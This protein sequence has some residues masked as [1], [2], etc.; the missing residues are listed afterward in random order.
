M[1]F[2]PALSSAEAEAKIHDMLR[3]NG[4]CRLPC[5]L[6]I[7]P[8][9]DIDMIGSVF[10]PLRELVGFG[11]G[12]MGGS[13]EVTFL[14]GDVELGAWFSAK[15]SEKQP[16]II[17]YLETMISATRKI[18]YADGSYEYRNVYDD[19]RYA[20]YFQYY[21]LPYLLSNYG[22][23]SQVYTTIEYGNAAM[24]LGLDYYYMF[25]DYS[26]RGWVARLDMPLTLANDM[27]IGCPYQAQTKLTLWLPGDTEMEK[28]YGF[29]RGVPIYV[30]TLEESTS[31]TLDEFYQQFK[32]PNNTKCLETPSGIYK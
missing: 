21:T 15:I 5:F 22:Q 29:S 11:Y 9:Q 3:N 6:G 10:S 4:G 16:G 1:T 2:L 27:F 12:D 20:E 25:L 8:G 23:P 13:M 26:D 28:E 31:F 17:K 7:T 19:P 32:D 18:V 14:Q 24:G 30:F